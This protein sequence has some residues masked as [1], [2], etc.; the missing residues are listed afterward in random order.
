M[1]KGAIIGIVVVVILIILGTWYMKEPRTP[2]EYATSTPSTMGGTPVS[3]SEVN[4]I[5]A[6]AGVDAE[7]Q[8]VDND[9]NQL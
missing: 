2:G 4:A 8:T 6:D 7:F 5:N 1:N 9:I 3:E